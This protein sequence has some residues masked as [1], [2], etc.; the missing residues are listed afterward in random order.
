M[1]PSHKQPLHWPR[2]EQKKKCTQGATFCYARMGT[3][4]ALFFET[5]PDALICG[6]VRLVWGKS[7]L[8]SWAGLGLKV[9]LQAFLPLVLYSDEGY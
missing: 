4:P 2:G 6:W 9:I 1:A 5:E 7:E 8:V 3:A